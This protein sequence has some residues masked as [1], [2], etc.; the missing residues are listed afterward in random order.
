MR[1]IILGTR[2]EGIRVSR[3]ATHANNSVYSPIRR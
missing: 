1:R 2:Q 3:D